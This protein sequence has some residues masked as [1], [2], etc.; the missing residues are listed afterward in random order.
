[1][2]S[3]LNSSPKTAR[4][5]SWARRALAA[6]AFAL[7]AA[8]AMTPSTAQ[9]WDLCNKTSYIVDAAI[10]TENESGPGIRASGW[11]RVRPG[12]CVEARRG[13]QE[14]DHVWLYA[15]SSAFHQDGRRIWGGES[16]L[17]IKDAAFDT[18]R[19]TACELRGFRSVGFREVLLKME[20]GRPVASLTET[21]QFTL[22]KARIAGVQRLLRD[23]GYPLGTI[24]AD[25]GRVTQRFA[26][27]FRSD[28]GLQGV[29]TLADAFID[30]LERQAGARSETSGLRV[31]NLAQDKI[32][33]ALAR[34]DDQGKWAARGWWSIGSGDCLLL[35]QNMPAS[36]PVYLFA[37]TDRLRRTIIGGSEDF[38]L[39]DTRFI[40]RV[41]ESC[42]QQ[43]Y[44]VASF[45]SIVRSPDATTP[46]VTVTLTEEDFELAAEQ[47]ERTAT[48]SD[49]V[50]TVLDLQ[51]AAQE[52]SPETEPA[53]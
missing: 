48:T 1:M 21:R 29:D 53:N 24:D 14:N 18:T 42:L 31:C 8:F 23:A 30:A 12:A 2:S 35:S 39:S 41:R 11:L 50:R 26:D 45:R 4:A 34:T 7:L 9:A 22:E 51:A 46:G 20:N 40:N 38:C 19:H 5:P 6:A 52:G 27:Q 15:R 16:D 44:R 10:A 17:C 28:A 33:T 32:W 37:E 3:W 47:N 13:G 25:L 49:A 36:E 43:G